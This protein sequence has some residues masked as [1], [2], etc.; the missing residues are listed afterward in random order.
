MDSGSA[1]EDTLAGS[2]ELLLS[3]AVVWEQAAVEASRQRDRKSADNFFNIIIPPQY[4]AWIGAVCIITRNRLKINTLK[5]IT[6]NNLEVIFV[7]IHACATCART[8]I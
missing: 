8:R 3:Y 5:Q 6:Y 2:D 7:C 4:F 1:S